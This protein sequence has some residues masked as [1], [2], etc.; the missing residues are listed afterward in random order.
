MNPK[1]FILPREVR[2][3]IYIFALTEEIWEMQDTRNC[4]QFNFPA[5]LGDPKGFYFPLSRGHSILKVN[6]RIRQEALP[7]A[8]RRTAFRLS[9]IDDLIK[10]LLAVGE[11]GR[12]NIESLEF[13]WQSEA[14]CEEM[15]PAP[16]D[17]VT[18]LPTL[19]AA[20]CIQLLKQC[21]RLRILR[22]Y[23]DSDLISK[24]SVDTFQANPSIRELCAL[25]GIKMVEIQG[26]TLEPLE[27]GAAK[28]LK[29]RLVSSKNNG[30]EDQP[31][32]ESNDSQ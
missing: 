4:H 2:K 19:H 14:E 10:L 6:K 23:I 7:L 31:S 29:E 15:P 26:L 12:N 18:A 9:D 21:K 1:F 22:L 17:M 25:R 8:Y 27:E 30:N 3:K 20:R 16:E 28:W 32:G 11:L 5:G 24:A 13:A